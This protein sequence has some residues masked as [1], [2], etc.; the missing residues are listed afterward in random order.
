MILFRIWKRRL[1]HAV[2][3]FFPSGAPQNGFRVFSV[4]WIA[5]LLQGFKG[6]AEIFGSAFQGV[7]SF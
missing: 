7:N 1:E 4:R 3:V 6:F 5:A 2:T